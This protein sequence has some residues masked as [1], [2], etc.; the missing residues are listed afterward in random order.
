M[1]LSPDT[2][3]QRAG[4]WTR[5]LETNACSFEVNGKDQIPHQSGVKL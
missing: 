3:G 4:T 5:G 1:T 2:E